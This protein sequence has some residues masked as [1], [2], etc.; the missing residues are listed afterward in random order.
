MKRLTLV[1]IIILS[2]SIN[3]FG[4]KSELNCVGAGM[5]FTRIDALES[6]SFGGCLDM[7]YKNFHLDF[8]S[9]L[10]AGEGEELDF[11]SSE[12]EFT[13]KRSWFI[14]NA[15][16]AI[17]IIDN[18]FITPKVGLVIVSDIYEDYV[19]Q[20]TYFKSKNETEPTYQLAF[21]MTYQFKKVYIKASLGTVETFAFVFGMSIPSF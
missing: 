21:D 20:T 9:N 12:T 7:T 4:Q 16:Y 3:M 17:H 11:S 10:A 8:A 13:N 14:I 18:I 1:S 19:G 2:V 15:G 6:N 5:S